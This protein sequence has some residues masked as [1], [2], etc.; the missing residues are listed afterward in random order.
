MPE[1]PQVLIIIGD[2]SETLDTMYPYYRL[3]EAGM[4]PVVAAPEKRRYQMVMHEVKPGWTITKEWEG[5]TIQADITFA[6]IEPDDYA[7]IM[8]SGGRAPEYIRYDQDLVRVTKAFFAAEKPIASV[9]H[10]VEIP[11]YAD[12][13]RGRRM[14]TVPKCQFDLEVCGGIFVDEPC[15]VDGNLVS[16]RTFHDN[17]HYLGPWIEMLVKA[18]SGSGTV[19]SS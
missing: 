17:G 2:A 7:G 4:Q 14:A 12:C 10:G 8:F 11:A 18:T 16:G 3:I 1:R 19:A 5:Y 9:C 15:V 6:E 13:V